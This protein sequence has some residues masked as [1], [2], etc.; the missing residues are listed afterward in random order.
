[1]YCITRRG[2]P[3]AELRPIPDEGAGRLTFGCD[4]G[5]VT[6]SAD[7]DAPIPGFEPYGR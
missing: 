5:K 7:F 2:R 4:R 3:V 6:V 1:M